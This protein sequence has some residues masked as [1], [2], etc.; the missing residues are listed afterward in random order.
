LHTHIVNS[1]TRTR[2]QMGIEWSVLNGQ[3][4]DRRIGDVATLAGEI[5]LWEAARSAA[6]ETVEWRFTT[7]KARTKLA[8]LYPA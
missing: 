5:A 8:R 7:E 3:C 1:A 6:K 2:E 4:L